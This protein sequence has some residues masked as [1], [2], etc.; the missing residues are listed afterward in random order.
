MG[1]SPRPWVFLVLLGL[2]AG[3]ASV[4][5]A[6]AAPTASTCARSVPL[7]T[8]EVIAEARRDAYRIGQTALVDVWVTDRFTGLPQED[9][10]AG[11]FLEGRD[12]HA[13]VDASKTDEDGHALLRLRLRLAPL[14]V[15]R[16]PFVGAGSRL[17][18]IAPESLRPNSQGDVVF[19]MPE[20]GGAIIYD[21][22]SSPDPA[23]RTPFPNNTVPSGRIDQAALYLI[24]RLL[25]H[26]AH[27]E[28]D[29]ETRPEAEKAVQ[30][31]LATGE[32][33]RTD[34]PRK[35]M[36]ELREQVFRGW[37]SDTDAGPLNVRRRAAGTQDSRILSVADRS[38]L[39]VLARALVGMVA[40]TGQ[41]WQE[42]GRPPRR[43]V[44]AQLV[45]LAWNGLSHLE[46]KPKLRIEP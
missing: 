24:E 21:P 19:P 39:P 3:A 45:N 22:L 29:A 31:G 15:A 25:E 33:Y 36:K 16:L 1:R 18:S 11:A 28:C 10:D 8:F 44:A 13:V 9:V 12:D 14:P 35:Q 46:H 32:W 34:I 27:E 17:L 42:V 5:A 30:K 40:L 41:W 7:E 43:V 26:K 4:P 20:Q 2:L 37:P 6:A 23:L 38:L